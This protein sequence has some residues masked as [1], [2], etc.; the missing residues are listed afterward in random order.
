[1]NTRIPA[2]YGKEERPKTFDKYTQDVVG[3]FTF[4]YILYNITKCTIVVC[5]VYMKSSAP[6]NG[7]NLK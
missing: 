3:M 4:F 7:S 1:M 5:S 6:I 2:L